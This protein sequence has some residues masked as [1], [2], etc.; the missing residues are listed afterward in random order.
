[1]WEGLGNCFPR[2]N[3]SPLLFS[4]KTSLAGSLD[5]AASCMDRALTWETRYIRSD[6]GP[7][8]HPVQC[9][10]SSFPSLCLTFSICKGG[11]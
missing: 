4:S 8:T 5:P 6:P 9:S 3:Y 11:V 10:A 2:S 1:M 7:A